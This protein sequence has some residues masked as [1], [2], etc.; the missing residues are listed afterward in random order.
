VEKGEEDH[1]DR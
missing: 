1:L